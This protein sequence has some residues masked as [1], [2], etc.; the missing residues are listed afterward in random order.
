MNLAYT[1]GIRVNESATSLVAPIESDS[2]VIVAVGTAPVN[3]VAKPTVNEPVVAYTYAEAVEKMGFSSDFENYTL[4]EVID[5]AFS[6]FGVCPIVMINVLDPAEHK[7]VVTGQEITVLNKKAE[8]TEKGIL[9]DS[10]IVKDSTGETTYIEDTDYVL[11]FSMEGNLI[12]A[13]ADDGAIT[14]TGKI[15]VSYDKLDPTA[16]TKTEI[17]GGYDVSAG[18]YKGLECVSQVYPKLGIVT[19]QIIAPGF[20]HDP[21]VAAVMKAK[22]TNISGLFKATAIADIDSDVGGAESYDAVYEWKNKN[23]YS[24]EDLIACWPMVKLGDGVYHYSTFWAALTAKTDGQN[25][26]IPYVSPSNKALPITGLVTKSGKEIFLDMNQANLLNGYGVCTAINLNGWRSWGN[27]T[28]VYPSNTDV[29]DRFIP[30]RR[31]FSWWGNSFIQTYFQKVDNPMNKRLIEAIVDSENIRANGYV[32]RGMMAGA[33]IEF[34]LS[35]NP[36]TDLLNGK[37]R[38]RQYMTPFPPAE[39]IENTLEFDT[40]MLE[41]ALG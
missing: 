19:G 13:I 20:S 17:V 33:K 18:T 31:F 8:V 39:T 35:E 40:D 34:N 25:S 26:N 27:N 28:S 3:L 1:H 4:C 2:A 6:K 15:Q 21:I 7:T 23:S 16:I 41:K 29:K 32:S 11:S 5:A 12:I 24:D 38:F 30:V 22:T 36:T 9:L 37:I 14:N 10:V